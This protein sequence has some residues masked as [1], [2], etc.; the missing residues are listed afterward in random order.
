MKLLVT[1]GATREPIDPVRYLSNVST[2]RTGARLATILA[3]RGHDVTLLR[4]HGAAMPSALVTTRGFG[5][6]SDL[7]AQLRVLLGTGDYDAVI[8]AAAVADYRPTE[9]A[10]GKISSAADTLTLS[11][12]RNP[13]LLPQLRGFSPGPLTVVGFKLTVGADQV[14]REAA[15]AAQFS[16]GGVDVVVHNDLDEMRTASV[17]PFRVFT[18]AQASPRELAGEV[19]L[20]Q[21]LD[22]WIAGG[23]L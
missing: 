22:D 17:H 13:K 14:E 1:A 21:V 23:Q 5:S 20:A 4:G 18:G 7:G 8:M 16:T 12:I 10:A 2:G 19:A 9:I 3:E 11:L 6:A 15:V